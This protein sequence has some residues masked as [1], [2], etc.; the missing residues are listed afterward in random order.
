MTGLKRADK[1]GDLLTRYFV[2]YIYCI[3]YQHEYLVCINY[4][5][6]SIFLKFRI[7]ICIIIEDPCNEAVVLN[8]RIL[9]TYWQLCFMFLFRDVRAY[10]LVKEATWTSTADYLNSPIRSDN[11]YMHVPATLVYTFRPHLYTRSGH[12]C[13]HVSATLTY[14]FRSHLYTRF[15]HTC[16]HVS[17]TLVYTFRHTLVYTFR[18]HLWVYTF[19]Q[20][21]HTSACVYWR[22]TRYDNLIMYSLILY[23]HFKY[24]MW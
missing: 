12:T 10:M 4:C 1:Q 5:K 7:T 8:M 14:T 6:W 3:V 21:L 22:I 23:V 19:H 17:A 15:G 9:Q 13:I 20:H 11:T 16:T 24:T 18:P 2:E